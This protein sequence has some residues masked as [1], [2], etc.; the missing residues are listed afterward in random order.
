[1]MPTNH[2]YTGQGQVEI[3][4]GDRRI[5]ADEVEVNETTKI[6][7]LKG[8]VVLVLGEDIFTGQEGQFNLATRAASC[9]APGFS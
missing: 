5:S 3:D 2:L 9:T 7:G 4:Q 1:M 8:N 6:A